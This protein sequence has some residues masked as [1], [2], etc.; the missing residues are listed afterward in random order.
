MKHLLS[1]KYFALATL[2]AIFVLLIIAFSRPT[3]ITDENGRIIIPQNNFH[4]PIPE[5]WKVR[6]FEKEPYQHPTLDL[7]TVEAMTFYTGFGFSEEA[8]AGTLTCGQ[9]RTQDLVYKNESITGVK[10]TVVRQDATEYAISL[11]TVGTAIDVETFSVL[12]FRPVNDVPNSF[13]AC[14]LTANSDIVEAMYNQLIQ[15]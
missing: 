8:Q 15:L 11:T 3:P 9:Y 5:D 6:M 12:S 4:L 14:E 2:L 1:K 13:T 7:R 10:E